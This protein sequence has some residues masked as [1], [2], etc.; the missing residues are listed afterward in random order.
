MNFD[1]P[2]CIMNVY[3]RELA[4]WCGLL[5]DFRAKHAT[6]QGS[7]AF[8]SSTSFYEDQSFYEIIKGKKDSERVPW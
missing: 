6:S 1:V 4:M 2:I 7:Q 5:L 8:K 3:L